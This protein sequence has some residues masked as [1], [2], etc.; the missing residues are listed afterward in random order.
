MNIDDICSDI[1][2]KWIQLIERTLVGAIE[3]IEGRVPT[4]EEVKLHGKRVVNTDRSETYTW[5]GQPII[6]I[7]SNPM[8]FRD[9]KMVMELESV[10]KDEG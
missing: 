5:K 3:Q 2:R 7:S 4:N 1:H 8:T 10:F 6:S 9:G